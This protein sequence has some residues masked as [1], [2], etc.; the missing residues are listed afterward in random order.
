[1]LTCS[2]FIFFPGLKQA[3]VLIIFFFWASFELLFTY[4]NFSSSYF[5]LFCIAET[6]GIVIDGIAAAV[7]QSSNQSTDCTFPSWCSSAMLWRWL[8]VGDSFRRSCL[9]SPRKCFAL[10]LGA[11][12]LVSVVLMWKQQTSPGSGQPIQI[13]PGQLA[14]F[15]FN[16]H[17]SNSGNLSLVQPVFLRSDSFAFHLQPKFHV[18][19]QGVERSGDSK[20]GDRFEELLEVCNGAIALIDWLRRVGNSSYGVLIDCLIWQFILGWIWCSV[21]LIDW[22]IV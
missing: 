17:S 14:Q 8:S 13:T 6:V 5:I 2:L 15:A 10:L 19:G 1:M 21:A 11:A 4:F 20:S 9:Y 3:V 16:S 18:C 22:L 12:V 7:N